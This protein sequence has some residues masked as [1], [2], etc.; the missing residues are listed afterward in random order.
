MT[1]RTRALA[2]VPARGGSKGLVRKNVLPVGGKPLIA[3]TLDAAA[4]ARTIDRVVVSS[5]DEEIIDVARQ[6]GAD[7]PFRRPEELATDETPTMAVVHHAIDQVGAGYDLVVLLQPT[8]PLRRAEDID[9]AVERCLDLAAPACVS[10]TRFDKSIEWLLEVLPDGKIATPF[11]SGSTPSRRQDATETYQ[12][13]GAIYVGRTAWVRAQESFLSSGT[14]AH[15]MPPE[16]SV[17]V[18]S[19]VDLLLCDAILRSATPW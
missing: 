10:V 15:I 14:V 11:S 2:I 7:V 16:R 5:D 3:W 18:D 13:N 4:A 19:S 9:A 17:D 6:H 12:L 8:S 1:A